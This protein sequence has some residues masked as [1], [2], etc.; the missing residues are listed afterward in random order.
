MWLP[1][2]RQH[3][4]L[5]LEVVAVSVTTA[6]SHAS[7]LCSDCRPLALV[8]RM[9]HDKLLVV[10]FAPGADIVLGVEHSAH[11]QVNVEQRSVLET[12]GYQ[13]ESK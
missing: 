4:A 1:R 6:I 2:S 10:F 3:G 7:E 9:E 13:W 12:N 11:V 5:V 8:Q